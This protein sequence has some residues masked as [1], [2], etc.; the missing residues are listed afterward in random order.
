MWVEVEQTAWLVVAQSTREDEQAVPV[1]SLVALVDQQDPGL[2]QVHLVW[3]VEEVEL[4]PPLTMGHH[5]AVATAMVSC[6]LLL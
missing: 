6:S 1:A 4:L 2:T 5:L 3:A